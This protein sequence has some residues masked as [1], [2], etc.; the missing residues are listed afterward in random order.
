MRQVTPACFSTSS[1][2]IPER[3]NSAGLSSE[4][5]DRTMV[6]ALMSALPFGPMISKAETFDPSSSRLR[7]S[8]SVMIVRFC[9]LRTAGV[10]QA[11]ATV[12]RLPSLI[13]RELGVTPTILPV[14]WPG[15][16]GRPRA[17]P[18]RI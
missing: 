15:M 8:V 1:G 16:R 11:S 17:S 18:A 6:A 13:I 3:I 9:R 10:S 7:T 5:A 14:L 2:P 4:P 12:T